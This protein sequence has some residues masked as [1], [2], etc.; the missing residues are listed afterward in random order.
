MV[1]VDGAACSCVAKKARQAADQGRR[2]QECPGSDGRISVRRRENE[3]DVDARTSQVLREDPDSARGDH[4]VVLAVKEE[5]GRLEATRVR[6]HESPAATS[7]AALSSMSTTGSSGAAPLSRI[8]THRPSSRRS[9]ELRTGGVMSFS[10]I[11]RLMSSRT[12]GLI[13]THRGRSSGARLTGRRGRPGRSRKG[14]AERSSSR[15]RPMA[16]TAETKGR[17]FRVGRSLERERAGEGRAEQTHRTARQARRVRRGRGEPAHRFGFDPRRATSG[18]SGTTTRVP[19]A[20]SAEATPTTRGSFG[21]SWVMPCTNT[22]VLRAGLVDRAESPLLGSTHGLGCIRGGLDA[23][24][25]AQRAASR[26]SRAW[27]QL[28]TPPSTDGG[29]GRA[30]SPRAP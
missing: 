6:P 7:P 2:V 19:V 21:P 12:A 9:A 13:G 20:A 15:R 10:R 4:A 16:P 25:S 1:H 26:R 14:T 18:N 5:D 11:A 30:P 3:V 17:P 8:L 29:S 22:T 24:R 23:S 28:T 27:G